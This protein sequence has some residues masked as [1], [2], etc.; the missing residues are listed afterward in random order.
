MET[1]AS[2]HAQAVGLS[3]QETAAAKHVVHFG[4]G[5]NDQGPAGLGKGDGAWAAGDVP[6]RGIDGV[7]DVLDQ[8]L[9]VAEHDRAVDKRTVKLVAEADQIIDGIAPG[10]HGLA[11]PL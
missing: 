2:W 9:D 7:L 10:H 8:G 5:A 4:R 3:S 6:E 11:G 1:G